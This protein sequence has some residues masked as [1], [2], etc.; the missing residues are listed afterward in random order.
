MQAAG[1]PVLRG[2]TLNLSNG[3]VRLTLAGRIAPGKTVS[4]TL[5]LRRGDLDLVRTIIW[6]DEAPPGGIF[7]YS[8]GIRFREAQRGKF[9]LDIFTAE[10]AASERGP[11]TTRTV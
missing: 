10:R 6:S 2:R 8:H 7:G 5:H 3:G 11:S 1:V 9:A 4:V